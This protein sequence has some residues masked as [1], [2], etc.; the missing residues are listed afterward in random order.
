[1]LVSIKGAGEQAHHVRLPFWRPESTTRI[2][3]CFNVQN[4]NVASEIFIKKIHCHNVEL[5]NQLVESKIRAAFDRG[6]FD[7][8]PGHGELIELDDAQHIAAELRVPYRILKNA[9]YIPAE[10]HLHREIKDVEQLLASTNDSQ[11][12]GSALR[13]LTVL[14][15]QIE[16]QRQRP[17]N[18]QT[19]QAYYQKIIESRFA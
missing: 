11:V 14:R 3:L 8:L 15:I 5:L 16:Q 7:D 18:L 2:C 10:I 19:E 9:G 17:L 4:F 13:R 1:M 12:S 6:D